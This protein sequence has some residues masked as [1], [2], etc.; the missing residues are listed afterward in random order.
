MGVIFQAKDASIEFS[1][2]YNV[3]YLIDYAYEKGFVK[4]HSPK[5][6][7]KAVDQVCDQVDTTP[8]NHMVTQILKES[9]SLLAAV[10]NFVEKIAKEI[11]HSEVSPNTISEEAPKEA[12]DVAERIQNEMAKMSPKYFR[13]LRQSFDRELSALK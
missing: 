8:M 11:K 12:T 5:A 2:S 3:G 13:E 7:R 6:L 1:L 4:Q 9:P 10:K